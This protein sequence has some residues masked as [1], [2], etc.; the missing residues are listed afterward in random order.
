MQDRYRKAMADDACAHDCMESLYDI[1]VLLE[2]IIRLQ[3]KLV[4]IAEASTLLTDSHSSTEP[5]SHVLVPRP[6]ADV[7]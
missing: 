5:Q 6:A 2:E 3:G 7:R 1:P 4:G